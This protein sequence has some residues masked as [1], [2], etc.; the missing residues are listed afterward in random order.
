[1]ENF[2]EDEKI[3]NND[4]EIGTVLINNNYP[5]ALVKYQNNNFNKIRFLKVKMEL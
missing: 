1:M 4:V 3:F 5:F 2:Y